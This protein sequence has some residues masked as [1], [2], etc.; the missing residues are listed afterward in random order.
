MSC[1]RRAEGW[2]LI[3]LMLFSN[4]PFAQQQQPNDMRLDSL[5]PQP[6]PPPTVQS[7]TIVSPSPSGATDK[8]F[9]Q[10]PQ[11]PKQAPPAAM[12]REP[13]PPA[14]KPVPLERNE[15]QEFVLKSTG[16]NLPLFG[17]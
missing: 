14:A 12:E 1:K 16:H 3:A 15:Y 5:G 9:Y 17:H 10:G 13:A 8:I 2:A 11:A 6:V 4:M 7:P